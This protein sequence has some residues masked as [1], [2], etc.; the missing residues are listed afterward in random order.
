MALNKIIK[1]GDRWFLPLDEK[2]V[3]GVIQCVGRGTGKVNCPFCGK[4]LLIYIWSFS[5]C[6]KNCKCG[7]KLSFHGAYMEDKDY[8]KFI[9]REERSIKQLLNDDQDY[10]KN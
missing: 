4:K 8:Q 2:G 3:Y 6:G 1:R 9:E 10:G 5:G 7:A